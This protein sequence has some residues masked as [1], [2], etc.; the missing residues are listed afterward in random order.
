[1]ISPRDLPSLF[2][3]SCDGGVAE[4]QEIIP[5][6]RVTAKVRY[7]LYF[8][9][10]A[11]WP[12]MTVIIL[13]AGVNLTDD[14]A[15]AAASQ[16]GSDHIERFPLRPT[17]RRSDLFTRRR[18]SHFLAIDSLS[19]CGPERPN[20]T[21]KMAQCAFIS[22]CASDIIGLFSS[23]CSLARHV[24][25]AFFFVRRGSKREPAREGHAGVCVKSVSQQRKPFCVQ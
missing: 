1:M 10:K 3:T 15:R 21:I 8:S 11:V 7:G 18:D 13:W 22:W 4:S 14:G 2:R 20:I 12:G 9:N 6:L 24:I 23:R 16:L 25:S 17:T 5:L 19:V